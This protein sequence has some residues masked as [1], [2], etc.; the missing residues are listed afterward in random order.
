VATSKRLEH[1]IHA[2]LTLL[3][4]PLMA[5]HDQSTIV[6]PTPRS[7]FSTVS[8]SSRTNLVDPDENGPQTGLPSYW[9]SSSKQTES[10]RMKDRLAGIFQ[11]WR[12][13]VLGSCK[14]PVRCRATRSI[15]CRV[16]PSPRDATHIRKCFSLLPD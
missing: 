2:V 10:P 7:R 11:G 1:V 9:P 3:S 13:I 14:Q 6:P 5:L 8:T 4:P 12:V 16:E 15:L